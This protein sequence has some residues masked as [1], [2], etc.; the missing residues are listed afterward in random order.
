[1]EV[2]S[3]RGAV[4]IVTGAAGGI[5]A[6]TAVKFAAQGWSLLLCDL[7]AAPLEQVAALL[8]AGGRQVETLS[9]DIADRAFPAQLVARLGDR[10]VNVFAHVA[11]LT[12]TSGDAARILE[13]NFCASAR[14]VAALLPRMSDGGCAVLISSMSAHM[15]KSPEI[16]AAL[17]ALS[18]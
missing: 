4:A 7:H 3:G 16:E 8:R 12:P 5:G 6:A 14:L 15:L 1:M 13:V 10:S 2:P 9:G 18:G 11:G 17:N